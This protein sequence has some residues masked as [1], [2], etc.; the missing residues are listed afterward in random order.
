[1]NRREFLSVMGGATVLST[2]NTTMAIGATT[3]PLYL[4]GLVIVDFGNPELLRIGFPKA[5][6]HKATLAIV[7]QNGAGRT[8]T[9]KGNGSLQAT[10]LMSF[11]APR[12][13][14]PELIRM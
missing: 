4:R 13:A 8:M 9:I 1:M 2:V 14:V 12:I 7:P 10:N 3:T 5:P 6:R 11:D